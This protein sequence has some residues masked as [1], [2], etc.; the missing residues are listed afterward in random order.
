MARYT[1][2]VCR[3]CRRE[4]QKLYLKG[5]RCYGPK[6]AVD[7]RQQPPGMVA[8]AGASRR[9]PM[10]PSDYALQLREK[11]KC[12]R[13]YGVLERQFRRYMRIAQRQPGVTGEVLMQ[14]LE[15]RLDNAVYRA[16]LAPSRSAGRQA[17]LHRHVAVNGI[18]VDVPSYSVRPGDVVEVREKSR[19]KKPF[20]EAAETAGGSQVP[21]WL[22]V[23]LGQLKATIKSVPARTEIDSDVNEGLIVEFYAR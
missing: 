6:C 9:R 21:G 7:K 23:D 2:A 13:I 17:V 8:A 1:K 10:R 12:R 15:R 19:S 16:G 14:Q 4:A 20:S 22:D 3:L 11:Q 5:A 18:V